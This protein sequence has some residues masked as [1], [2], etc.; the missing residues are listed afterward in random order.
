MIFWF[1]ITGRGYQLIDEK[2]KE[3]P[4]GAAAGQA[5]AA[6][7]QGEQLQVR[8]QLLSCHRAHTQQQHRYRTTI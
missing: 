5:A 2:R 6:A 3:E 4:G 1:A 7:G 8:Q